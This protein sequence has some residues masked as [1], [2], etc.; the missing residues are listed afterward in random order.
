MVIPFIKCLAIMALA[1]EGVDVDAYRAKMT[2]WLKEAEPF[3]RKHSLLRSFKSEVKVFFDEG[4]DISEK[5]GQ[6]L[7]GLLKEHT[8]DFVADTSIKQAQLALIKDLTLFFKKDS[9]P[10][11]NR[12]RSNISELQDNHLSAEFIGEDQEV[13]DP[14]IAGAM[15]KIVRKLMGRND[16][17]LTLNE[18]RDLAV[19]HPKDMD[20]YKELRK[21]FLANYKTN[22]TRFIRLQR[23][24]VIDVKIVA[25]YLE[26]LGCNNIPKGF[27]GGIDE[28][29][30][31]YTTAGHVIQGMLIGEVVMNPKYDPEKDN[32]YVCSLK[33]N[34]GQR[35]RTAHF[36]NGNK[37]ARFDLINEFAAKLDGFRKKW[38]ADMSSSDPQKSLLSTMVEMIYQTQ[39]RVGTEGN[40]ADGEPT[41]GL[42]TAL[43]RHVKVTTAGVE[44]DYP[45]KKGTPQHHLVKPD[46]VSNRK[47]VTTVKKLLAGKKPN[48]PLFTY[49][50]KQVTSNMVNGYLKSIGVKVTAHKF[51]HLLATKMSKELVEQAPFKKGE[52]SQAAVEKWV[53][54]EFKKIGE[55]LHHQSGGKTGDAKTV[56]TTAIA[57]Y[58]DPQVLATFFTKLGLR[59]PKWVPEAYED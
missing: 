59:V 10:A 58:C 46:T 13:S 43:I 11:W 8:K 27:E 38:V 29:G 48:D 12:I 56:G 54:E 32:T 47:I 6:I 39:A 22:L 19:S 16:P 40:E 49:N 55:R 31:L 42:T 30:R 18:M 24:P 15:T 37:K 26:A 21:Q 33:S 52:A 34:P 41:Y 1:L 7:A 17:V 14:S 5:D 45:G 20:R 53:K 9:R 50:G 35:L 2:A 36:I 25:K 4:M 44:F 51:R 28:K 3:L 57:S 23:K